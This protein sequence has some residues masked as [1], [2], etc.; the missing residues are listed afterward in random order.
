MYHNICLQWLLFD[1]MKLNKIQMKKIIWVGSLIVFVKLTDV[2][3]TYNHK[4]LDYKENHKH[5]NKKK[6]YL[7]VKKEPC[8]L[9]KKGYFSI[10]FRS[11]RFPKISYNDANNN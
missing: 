3:S 8:Y 1:L 10:T 7:Y 5:S 4:T 9:R 11:L 6:L 2:K